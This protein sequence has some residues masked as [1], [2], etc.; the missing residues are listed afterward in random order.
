MLT[1][2]A[3]PDF[4]NPTD[5]TP[6]DG[7]YEIEVTVSD[8]HGGSDVET[9][10]VTVD[11]VNEDPDIT[12]GGH[13]LTYTENAPPRR[14]AGGGVVTDPDNPAN[15][16]GGSLTVDFDSPVD[17]EDVLAIGAYG[18][19]STAPNAS[20]FDVFFDVDGPGG[21][22]PV[23]FGT[24]SSNGTGGTSLVIDFDSDATLAAVQALVQ[25]ITFSTPGETAADITAATDRELTFTLDDGQSGSGDEAKTI[26]VVSVNDR[27]VVL[28]VSLVIPVYTENDPRIRLAP[29]ASVTD[30]DSPNFEDGTL[31]AAVTNFDAG[32][33]LLVT[34][35][36]GGPISLSGDDVSVD[37]GG[38]ALR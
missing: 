24:T 31:T 15:F 36:A 33:R 19:I 27:P 12:F 3:A 13:L 1:F 34:A 4:E 9:I 17:S 2:D 26:D 30:V 16:D 37:D 23:D 18:G 22:D 8:G 11:N 35:P 21:A 38:G 20:F 29:T 28:G 25:A 32:D 10:L 7:I 14:I 6:T 5:A